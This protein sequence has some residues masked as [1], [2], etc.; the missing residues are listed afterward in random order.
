MK[1][2]AVKPVISM[3]DVVHSLL[4]LVFCRVNIEDEFIAMP[5][6]RSG[7]SISWGLFE[8]LRRPLLFP[9]CGV[10]LVLKDRIS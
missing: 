8:S 1:F 10:A 7:K 9:E 2:S 5:W 3:F 4:N 6:S